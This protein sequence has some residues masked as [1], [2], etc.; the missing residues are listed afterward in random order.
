MQ[1]AGVL[2]VHG[3][4][5]MDRIFPTRT[6]SLGSCAVQASIPSELQGGLSVSDR[7]RPVFTGVNGTLSPVAAV[8]RWL[9]L[10]LSPLL[11]FARRVCTWPPWF[12]QVRCPAL[13]LSV[14]VSGEDWT[15]GSIT[16]APRP[17]RP[18]NARTIMAI[19]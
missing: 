12:L 3:A 8:S 14:P 7:E 15:L 9:L 2:S 4:D 13:G 5:S 10:L 6:I 1:P 17:S 19:P 18:M 11:S 16:V